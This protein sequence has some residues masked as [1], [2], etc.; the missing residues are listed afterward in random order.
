[1]NSKPYEMTE[2]Q[3]QVRFFNMC[4]LHTGRF[5]DLELIHAIPN[6]G[7]RHLHTAVKMKAEGQRSG[8][9]DICLPVPREDSHGLYIEM[10]RRS[11]K[12]TKTGGLS[13]EQKKIIGKLCAN[14]YAVFVAY[15]WEEAWEFTKQYLRREK[16]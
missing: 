9:P 15:G 11:L 4:M 12:K 2:H 1:M 16:P 14:G 6:G 7:K 13:V 10:K 8:I 3:E 5:P